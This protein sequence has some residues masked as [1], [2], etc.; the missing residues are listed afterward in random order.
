VRPGDSLW[1]IAA[2]HLGRHATDAEVAQAW[3]TW[4]AANRDA[5][6]SDP[7]LIH[8]GLQ[9]DPPAGSTPS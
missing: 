6:G 9:L 1:A 4:W 7:G 3:P 2:A 5:V 8:P